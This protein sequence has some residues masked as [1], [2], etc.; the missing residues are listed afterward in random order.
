VFTAVRLPARK[1]NFQI[2]N[3]SSFN[4]CIPSKILI[5]PFTVVVLHKESD[6]REIVPSRLQTE[7][8]DSNDFEESD[9]SSLLQKA[10]KQLNVNL[11]GR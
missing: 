4:H 2:L 6:I 10:V 11:V 9:Q 1:K 8:I 5:T 7:E 3:Q